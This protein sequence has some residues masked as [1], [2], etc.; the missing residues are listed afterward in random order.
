MMVSGFL[1]EKMILR[2]CLVLEVEMVIVKKN[3]LLDF[4]LRDQKMLDRSLNLGFSL[5]WLQHLIV[6][7]EVIFLFF[8][9]YS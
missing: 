2:D 4:A 8:S 9:F 1:L 5:D 3:Y 7:A 6:H